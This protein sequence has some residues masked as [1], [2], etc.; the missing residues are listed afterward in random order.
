MSDEGLVK[1]LMVLGGIVV[2]A[3]VVSSSVRG[4]KGYVVEQVRLQEEAEREAENRRAWEELKRQAQ[5]AHDAGKVVCSRCLKQG[6]LTV[7][8]EPCANCGGCKGGGCNRDAGSQCQKCED[9]DEEQRRA[10]DD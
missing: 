3:K 8:S 4:I 5:E 9:Y 7:N 6:Y 1:A 10:S 2:A